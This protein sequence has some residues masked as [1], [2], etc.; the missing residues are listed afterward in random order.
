MTPRPVG[1][2]AHLGGRDPTSLGPARE[3][4][5]A[6][7]AGRSG[8]AATVI[9]AL[10]LVFSVLY[11]LSDVI[12]VGQG[13]FSVGQ[14]WLTLAAEAAIPVFVI[15]FAVLYRSQLRRLGLG[16]AVAY[17]YSYVV[18][19]GTVVYALLNHTKDYATLNE[20]LGTLMIVHGAIMVLAG[21]GFG[22]AVL[23]T[24]LLPVWAGLPLMVGVVLVATSQGLPDVVQLVA[25]GIRDL[26]FAGMGAA[27][28]LKPRGVDQYRLPWGAGDHPTS[29]GRV[30][31]LVRAHPVAVFIG[32]AFVISWSMWLPLLAA[33]QGWT[34]AEPWPALHLFGG[35]G[36]GVAA[37]VVIG[38]VHGRAGLHGL[39]RRLLAR[40]GRQRAW[41]FAV[42]VPPALLLAAA[43]LS[44]WLAGV[45]PLDL[46][47]SA[48]GR[49]TEFSTLP[50]GV[51]WVANLFFYGLGE[52]VGW[53][54]LLQPYLE[55]RHS[56]VTSAGL[57]SL[58][59][60]LWHLPLFGITPSYRAMPLV[61]FVGFAFSI[62]VASWIFAW[63]LHAGGGSLLVVVFFHAWFDIVTTSPLG[64]AGL[65]TAMGVGITLVGVVILRRLLHLPASVKV[66]SAG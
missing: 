10:A 51:W 9:G 48:L 21:L 4:P 25:I 13:G 57:V 53:R 19:S 26:G 58:P 55:R 65:P 61:G 28:L 50:I 40:R 52:E 7:P 31:E 59:W 46:N 60:A 5:P 15:G 18:F 45:S 14:L 20:H 1:L 12:E 44:S 54:G 43:P 39:G 35:L 34:D 23:R 22:V 6:R 16:S 33:V 38:L 11:F 2:T 32:L 29:S 8:H 24:R 64:L 49:S 47:W 42:L 66:A 56:V 30:R 37:V 17:A 3:K 62:W 41:A 27:L 63:L 36:P